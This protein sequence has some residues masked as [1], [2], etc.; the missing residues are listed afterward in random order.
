MLGKPTL[1]LTGSAPHFWRPPY[2]HVLNL[3]SGR[4]ALACDQYRCPVPFY[5]ARCIREL[6]LGTVIAAVRERLLA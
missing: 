3:D 4:C 2:A 1:V 5:R 6:E